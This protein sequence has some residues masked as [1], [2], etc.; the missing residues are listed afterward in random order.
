MKSE[1]G[2]GLLE[3]DFNPVMLFSESGEIRFLNRSGEL[4]ASFVNIKLFYELA[5]NYAPKSFGFKTTLM[6]LN[7]DKFNFF[8]ITVGYLS[9]D[10]IAI[11][12]YQQPISNT[13]QK[14]DNK[15]M[16]SSNIYMLIDLAASCVGEKRCKKYFDVDIP[17][18]RLHQNGFLK[19]LRHAMESM[20]SDFEIFLKLKIGEFKIVN[21]QKHK[22]IELRLTGKRGLSMDAALK[23]MAE[24][25]H[26][27]VFLSADGVILD[28]PMVV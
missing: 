16:V 4:L 3:H 27:G 18:F 17:E 19:L 12:L 26:V 8:A 25:C 22:L 9:E 21:E 6:L 20:N 5:V 28:I 15:E 14:L 23:N 10:E 1:L 2:F 7:Y 24:K 13:Q 11:I